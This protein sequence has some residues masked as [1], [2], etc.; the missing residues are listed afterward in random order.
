MEIKKHLLL[1]L[2]NLSFMRNMNG[3]S[4]PKKR[5]T[6]NPKPVKEKE[7]PSKNMLKPSETC[8]KKKEESST[9]SSPD[10]VNISKENKEEEFPYKEEEPCTRKNSREPVLEGMLLLHFHCI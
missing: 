8:R 9:S 10:P 3:R 7:E 1:P 4:K 2:E 5:R 6:R